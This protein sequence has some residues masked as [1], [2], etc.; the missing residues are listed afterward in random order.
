MK[1]TTFLLLNC[2]HIHVT[3]IQIKKKVN[4]FFLFAS[5]N[6]RGAV[7]WEKN[8]SQTKGH[9]CSLRLHHL[10]KFKQMPPNLPDGHI[11]PY[12]GDRNTSSHAHTIA[13]C[14][15]SVCLSWR[16]S[17]HFF[18]FVFFFF[19]FSSFFERG[20]FF[21]FFI[22]LRDDSK[23]GFIWGWGGISKGCTTMLF[24]L[25]PWKRERKRGWVLFCGLFKKT[26]TNSIF[27][28]M[29]VCMSVIC[30]LKGLMFVHSCFR[31]T[32]NS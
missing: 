6:I 26:D 2:S 9:I 7:R 24:A 17:F 4:I 16:C 5:A 27:G 21:F 10:L 30:I 28:G 29:S 23:G 20:L 13:H 32:H 15:Q 25:G 3:I 22:W 8:H 14:G 1:T 31:Y 11:V 19:F 18:C 12:Q